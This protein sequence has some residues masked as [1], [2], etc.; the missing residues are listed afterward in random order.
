MGRVLYT[1]ESFGVDSLTKGQKYNVVRDEFGTL[2]I[3]DASEEDYIYDF[4]NPRPL[5]GSSKGGNFTIVD[6]PRKLLKKLI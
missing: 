2:T 4:N 5:D 6:D 3:V 1:G